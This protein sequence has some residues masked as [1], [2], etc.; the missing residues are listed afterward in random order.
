VANLYG[1]ERFPLPVSVPLKALGHDVLTVQE[2][3]RCGFSDPDVLIFATSNNRIVL[4]QNRRDFIR[5]HKNYP[6][7]AGIIVC[8]EDRDLEALAQKIDQLLSKEDAFANKL[9]RINR[10]P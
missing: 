1:D 3:N 7:H 4:T 10:I 6:I 8:T 2:A 9:M 5:L